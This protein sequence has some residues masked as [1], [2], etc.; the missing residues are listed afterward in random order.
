MAWGRNL[1]WHQGLESWQGY[2]WIMARHE[3]ADSLEHWAGKAG[4]E[5]GQR[6]LRGK[7]FSFSR[8]AK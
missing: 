5:A 7:S 1:V 8:K 6:T 3:H 2:N 4:T